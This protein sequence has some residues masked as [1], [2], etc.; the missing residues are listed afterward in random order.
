MRK[1]AVVTALAYYSSALLLG[2]LLG[3][4]AH[5]ARD[6]SPAVIRFEPAS[7]QPRNGTKP[8]LT[9]SDRAV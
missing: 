5:Q 4:A 2:F 8:K 9:Y 3:T 1:H 7:N 6:K